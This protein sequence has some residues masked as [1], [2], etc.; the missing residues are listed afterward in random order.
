MTISSFTSLSIKPK[1]M[2]TFN[3]SLPSYTY[4]AIKS[5]RRFN[6]HVLADD[7]NGASLADTFAGG[8]SRMDRQPRFGGRRVYVDGY[9]KWNMEWKRHVEK[10]QAP[11]G[12]AE[13]WTPLSREAVPLIRDQGVLYTLRCVVRAPWV[14]G[15]KTMHGLNQLNNYTAIV[16][17]EVRDVVYGGMAKQDTSIPEGSIGLTYAHGQYRKAGEP[18]S[19]PE[20]SLKGIVDVSATLSTSSTPNAFNIPIKSKEQKEEPKRDTPNQVHSE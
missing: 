15:Q 13:P 1:K 8:Q 4:A 20:K 9:D 7:E 2:V 12:A 19:L 5:S 16:I 18:H 10:R 11:D 17:G 3:I 14:G 6:V